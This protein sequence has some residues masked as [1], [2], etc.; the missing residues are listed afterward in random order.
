MEIQSEFS[1]KDLSSEKLRTI[2]E[3]KGEMR[4]KKHHVFSIPDNEYGCWFS[5]Y[6][7]CSTVSFNKQKKYLYYD[8]YIVDIHP[9]LYFKIG[10]YYYLFYETSHSGYIYYITLQNLCI[11]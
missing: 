1:S 6:V 4:E 2:S 7:N 9:L 5:M 3:G 10:K 11:L 8:S